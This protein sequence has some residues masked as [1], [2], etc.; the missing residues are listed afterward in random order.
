METEEE[1]AKT[2]SEPVGAEGWAEFGVIGLGVMGAN[3]A[4]NI[5]E[6]GTKVAVFNRSYDRTIEFLKSAPS[7]RFAGAETLSAFVA[8]LASPRAILMMVPAG[9]AV[10]ETIEGLLPYLRTGDLL[11]D[12][13]NEFFEN[14]E[15]RAVKLAQQG[16][17]YLGM[18]VSGG[19]TGARHGPSLMPG[20]KAEA[21]ARAE[22]VLRKIA[23]QVDDG[24]CV[25]HIGPGGAG[26]YVKM[27]HN[28][29]EYGDM[30]LIAEIYDVL[31]RVGGLSNDRL[32]EVFAE[33]NEG[34]LESYLIEI[35]A[36]ILRRRDDE[37]QGALVDMILD[38]AKMKGTGSWTVRDA[39]QRMVPAPT[40]ASAVD[41]RL[42]SAHREL[43]LLGASKL[44]GPIPSLVDSASNS[45][46][47][48]GAGGAGGANRSPS[49]AC[50]D[51][52]DAL[53]ADARAALYA[54]KACS[55]A[56]GLM[57]IQAASR[58]LNWAIDI[59]E[60]ARIW[61]GGCIIRAAF[62][63][64]IQAAYARKPTLESLLFDADFSQELAARQEGWRRFITLG[65]ASGIPLSASCASLA[66]YDGVRSAR[67]P[68]NLT[69][70]QRDYFGAHTY[71]RC[72]RDGVFHTEWSEA[73]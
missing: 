25:T 49:G 10:D 8:S 38:Q 22:P 20:G 41:A 45:G 40:I 51:D 3:I 36:K 17:L 28:G 71:A 58:D 63:G 15:R 52:V 73:S 16:I 26:H 33:W 32:A 59:G 30:Q 18:G 27:I 34:E 46:N 54:A 50:I 13:G 47:A 48:G 1:E 43:R 31:R 69:Q 35:T 24:P 4:L 67:L 5:E 42:M 7:K 29:I 14:T 9:S 44:A 11:I 2:V 6:K 65:I 39:A 70:A 64:R 61:K 56:Q 55:Y 68:A 23:A 62:L 66:Y 57:L 12:G 60:V 37:T 19:E 53:I 21:Y 72:D